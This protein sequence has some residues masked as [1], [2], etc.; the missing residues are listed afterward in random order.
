MEVGAQ[1]E[2]IR[3]AE[4]IDGKHFTEY[5]EE[6]KMLKKSAKNQEL[7]DLLIK[8]IGA[9]EAGDAISHRGVAPWYYEELAKLYRNENDY[10]KEVEIL[11]RFAKKRHAPGIMPAKLL[12]RL[13]RA[14]QLLSKN[15]K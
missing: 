15:E 12:E 8:L 5:I 9:T 14:K 11:E 7:E 2:R 3:K 13:T 6:V 4:E 1:L 10:K